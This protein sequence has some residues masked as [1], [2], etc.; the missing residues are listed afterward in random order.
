[1]SDARARSRV[2]RPVLSLSK[3]ERRLRATPFGLSLSKG[4]RRLRARAA[5]AIFAA[6]IATPATA[7]GQ[8]PAARPIRLVSPFAAGGSTDTVGRLLAPRLSER[9]GRNVVVENRPGAGG[10]IGTSFV[11]KAVPDG[12]TLIF[13][14]GAFTAHS[15]VTKNLPYDPVRDFAWVST[16]LTYPFVVVVRTDSA[17]QTVSDLIAAAKKNPRTLNYGSVGTGSVFHLAAELFGS[18][19]G[20]E[21]THIP[22]KGGAEP[23]TELIAGRL[24]VIFTTATTAYPQVEARRMRALAV[25]SLKPAPQFPGVPTLAQT[26]P[27]Y[28]VVSFNG[29]GSPRKTPRAVVA[30]INR[31]IRTVLEQPDLRKRLIEQG[32]EV[33]PGTPEEMTRSVADDIRKWQR[34]VAERNIE[35]Q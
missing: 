8:Y 17:L 5:A 7:A 23:N 35:V 15:A 22:F 31:E 24:D 12:H 14:S 4:E 2:D 19:T 1:M 34:I 13:I 26:V 18:M 29:I 3:G 21:M 25:T 10:L 30:R 16:V 11:A 6:S 33:Q 27:G 28:E 9:L 20:T 32:N